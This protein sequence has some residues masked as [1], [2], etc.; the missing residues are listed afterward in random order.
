MDELERVYCPRC[1]GDSIE[2]ALA[3]ETD[4]LFPLEC[5]ECRVRFAIDMRHS[6][7]LA[8]KRQAWYP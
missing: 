4:T 2:V 3:Q 5:R 8:E 7:L 6:C 1:G